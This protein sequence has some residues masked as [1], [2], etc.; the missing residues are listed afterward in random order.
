MISR[1]VEETLHLSV[2][3]QNSSRCYIQTLQIFPFPDASQA[4]AAVVTLADA[5]VVTL[6]KL[7]F[8]A[9]TVG[10]ADDETGKLSL[11]YPTEI[12]D[13][14]N[15]GLF[16][17]K[18]LDPDEFPH[19]YADLKEAG[20]PPSTF[21]GDM[22]CPYALRGRAGIPRYAEGVMDFKKC[23]VPVLA[24]QAF[25]FRGGLV[26]SCYVHHNVV[27]CSGMSNFWKHFAD[28]VNQR[29]SVDTLCKCFLR[30]CLA[31]TDSRSWRKGARPV[32]AENGS[33]CTHSVFCVVSNRRLLH[34]R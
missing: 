31:S 22:F 20:M 1:V 30:L 24:V 2:M 12:P 33:R 18:K 6:E 29:R 7:P 9:G 32:G 27:D 19:T 13:V 28:S 3:D 17:S 8:L 11:R 34:K 5:L 14:H 16:A 25:F 10:P 15:T 4:E 26:L 21:T 23:V